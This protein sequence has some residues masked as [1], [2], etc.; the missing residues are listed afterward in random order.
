[1]RWYMRPPTG[2]R[3][4][5]P[6]R[7]QS[8]EGS[9]VWYYAFPGIGRVSVFFD[10]NGTVSNDAV[11]ELRLVAWVLLRRLVPAA[12]SSGAWSVVM[13]LPQTLVPVRVLASSRGRAIRLGNRAIEA[14][15]F[16]T[17]MGPAPTRLL[18]ED[19]YDEMRHI[20]FAGGDCSGLAANHL[21]RAGIFRDVVFL[22]VRAEKGAKA[23]AKTVLPP[24]VLT[25]L[26]VSK[27]KLRVESQ[28]VMH[29]ILIS[30]DAKRTTVALSPSQKSYQELGDRP[31][32]SSAS[33]T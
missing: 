6:E 16:L 13:L 11:T 2:L 27:G 5:P 1:M 22:P 33:P 9:A 3:V 32:Q 12:A 20:K 19:E 28:G 21:P 24:A 10:G 14:Q 29:Q 18:R 31:T 17:A 4:G 15:L 25:K 30:D 8:V 7:V 23:G 26:Y